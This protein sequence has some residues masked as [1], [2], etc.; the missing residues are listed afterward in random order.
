M[1][2]EYRVMDLV[3]NRAWQSRQPSL[4]RD[5]FRRHLEEMGKDGWEFVG[6]V[7]IRDDFDIEYP[8]EVFRRAK[9]GT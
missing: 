7:V 6:Q 9:E 5:G 1:I 8:A 3:V 2:F 4:V